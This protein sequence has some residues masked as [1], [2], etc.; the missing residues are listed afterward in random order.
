MVCMYGMYV[1]MYVCPVCMYVCMMP[2][3]LIKD[4]DDD[5]DERRM[6]DPHTP[7]GDDER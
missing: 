3:I 1:C 4:D 2:Q 5:D 6:I 7:L